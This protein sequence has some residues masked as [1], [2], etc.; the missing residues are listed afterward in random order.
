MKETMSDNGKI[1]SYMHWKYH[2]LNYE[3]LLDMYENQLESMSKHSFLA[4]W[5]FHQYIVCKII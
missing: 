5:N 3:E 1:K 4:A 2:S